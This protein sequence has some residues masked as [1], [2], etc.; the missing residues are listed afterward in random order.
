MPRSL[1]DSLWP[2]KHSEASNALSYFALFRYIAARISHSIRN[3]RKTM[4][5]RLALAALLAFSIIASA[6][7]QSPSEPFDVLIRNGTVVDGTGKRGVKAD[8]GVRGDHIVFIGQAKNA[9]AKTTIDA[10]NLVVAPGFI[11]VHSHTEVAIANPDRR[12]NEGVIR[13]GVTTIVG[14]PDG[15]QSPAQIRRLVAAYEKNGAGTNVAFYIGHNA[16]RREIVGTEH[17]LATAEEIEKM[18]ALVR[19]GMEMGCVGFSTGLMYEPGMWSDTNEVA[20]LAKVA[21]PFNGTYDS[22]VRD[23][24]QRFVESDAE[25]IEVGRR[26][27]IPVKIAHEKTVGLQNAGK[28]RVIIKMINAARRSGMEVVTDQY[29]YDGAATSTLAGIVVVP[30]EM[31]SNFDLKA[32]LRDPEKRQQLKQA[33][34]NGINGGFAWLKATGYGAMRITSSR[35]YPQLIGKYLSELAKERKVDPFDLVSDLLLNAQHPVGITLGAIKE[36]DVRELMIQPWN[37]IASDGG[38]SDG[39]FIDQRHPRSTGTFA[40][41]LGHYVRE[42]KLLSLEEAVRKM[43]S[44]PAD[45]LAIPERG[46]IAKGM[47]ADIAVF[48]P[49]TIR[50]R[51]TW[52]EP[53]LLA[54]G[55]RHVLVNGEFVLR[56]GQMTGK[57]PGKFLPKRKREVR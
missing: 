33:S 29:P 3:R 30:P 34:E 11:D 5:T 14:G 50:D 41:V 55:V 36:E 16:I 9:Q 56:D 28:N 48:D 27:G 12:W 35:D 10:S 57:A 24:V 21:K 2:G 15:S 17:R 32:A 18:K 51:S 1:L 53:Q 20:E 42:V 31:R 44:L 38:Y 37:M 40:R 19:E 4:K 54:E 13:Q 52:D 25:A 23:P 26:A 49:K 8:L 46:R 43:T 39:K 6:F 7:S 22:H 45:H 47:A